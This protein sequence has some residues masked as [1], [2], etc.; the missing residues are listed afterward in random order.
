MITLIYIA[1][2][3]ALL[4]LTVWTLYR[5]KDPWLQA[6]AAMVIVPLLLRVLGIK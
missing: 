2:T 1:I 6:T 4:G 3:A 5:E